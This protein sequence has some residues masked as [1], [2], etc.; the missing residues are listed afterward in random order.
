MKRDMYVFIG[1]KKQMNTNAKVVK[2]IKNFDISGMSKYMALPLIFIRQNHNRMKLAV[3]Y[4]PLL[5]LA[6]LCKLAT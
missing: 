1:A 6:L 5:F 3:S 4:E 2:R